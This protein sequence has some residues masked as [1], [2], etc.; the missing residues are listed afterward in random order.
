MSP[1][2]CDD[3]TGLYLNALRACRVPSNLNFVRYEQSSPVRTTSDSS[4]SYA[5][6]V[7]SN[8]S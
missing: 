7:I 1:V 4:V 8:R 2:V 6:A 5:S 3:T